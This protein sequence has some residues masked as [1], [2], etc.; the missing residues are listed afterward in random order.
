MDPDS[1]STSLPEIP[2]GPKASFMMRILIPTAGEEAA[3]EIAE[4][5][6]EVAKRMAAEVTVLHILR[7]GETDNDGI[8]PCLVFANAGGEA[9]VKVSS[10]TNS[11]DVVETILRVA[12]EE[13][14]DLILMGA[15]R[16]SLVENWLSADVMG[17][18]NVPV[19]VVPHCFRR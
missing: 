9:G 13:Q 14:T 1:E 6:M 15:S 17:K 7:E 12:N 2:A 5:V 16:G 4:Y 18:G 8:H 3:Q 10:R 11:G 19:L